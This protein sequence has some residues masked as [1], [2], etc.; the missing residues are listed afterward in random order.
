[1]HFRQ[2]S[3]VIIE[4]VESV[5]QEHEE[6]TEASSF[7]TRKQFLNDQEATDAAISNDRRIKSQAL[8]QIKKQLQRLRKLENLDLTFV[9]VLKE[10]TQRRRR[11]KIGGQ[12]QYLENLKSGVP[13]LKPT[14][15]WTSKLHVERHIPKVKQTAAEEVQVET[16]SKLSCTPGVSKSL[17]ET[18]K[19]K[20]Q[21]T[22]MRLSSPGKDLSIGKL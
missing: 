10:T 8:A 9:F 3:D 12:G 20:L 4:H 1:M 17:A 16:P 22:S 13:I 21:S 19:K 7:F 14:E 15:A 2:D 11:V 6:G 5:E 18:Q